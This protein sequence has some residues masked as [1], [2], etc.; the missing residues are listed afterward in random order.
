MSS[1]L[2][3]AVA[4]LAAAAL[5]GSASVAQRHASLTVPAYAP[6]DPRLVTA[7]TRRP[8]WWVGTG[9]SV[10]GLGLQMLALTLGPIIV[11]QSVLTSSIVFTTLAEQL[12]TGRRPRRSTWSGVGLTGLGLVGLLTALRPT[13][14]TGTVP[15]GGSMVAVAAGSLVIM[16]AA[17]AWARSPVPKG[18]AAGRVLA[19]AAATGLGY[20]ITAVALKTVG[21][22]LAAGLTV[23]LQHPALYVALTLGPA[24]ILLSQAALQQGRL[25]T[26]VVSVI[27]VVDPLVGLLA[28]LF[29][30][31]ETVAFGANVAV[32]AI[33]LIA[34]V[35][36]T[37]RSPRPAT[38]TRPTPAPRHADL[39]RVR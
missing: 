37:Q 34:G 5:L 4:A 3:A 20:G 6:G 36:L 21:T 29:W 19:L 11:V 10:V 16:L 24:A 15:P 35:V 13:T 7:L 2:G 27:L 28:G 38:P 9:A 1:V 32:C 22:Q 26:A 25:A 17:V 14:G 30:F 18:S 31:G 39:A 8:W 23:P 33:V 12:L